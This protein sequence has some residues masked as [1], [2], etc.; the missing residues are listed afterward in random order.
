MMVRQPR[1]PAG[2]K[3]NREQVVAD[4][5][6]RAAEQVRAIVTGEDWA[7]W[8][9]VAA[10]FP[11]LG[12]TNVMLVAAQ[13]PAATFLA[14][15]EEWQD[16]GRQVRKGEP[17]IQLIAEPGPGLAVGG[18]SQRAYP[19]TRAS[20]EQVGRGP[21]LAY[22][23]DVSQTSGPPDPD[24]AAP[25]LADGG[26]ARP[27]LWDA[28]T[29]LARREGFAVERA[30]CVAGDSETR[31]GAHRIRISP[32]LHSPAAARAL[33][34]ELGHV[35]AHASPGNPPGAST[36]GCRGI[37]KVE[38]DSIACIVATRL[39]MDTSIYTWP[40]V[41]SWAGG[42]PRARPEETV[43]AAG[44][45]I[46]Q[47]AGLAA[48]HLDVALFGV[49]GRHAP[50]VRHRVLGF[51]GTPDERAVPARRPVTDS[52]PPVAVLSRMLVDAERFYRVHLGDKWVPGYLAARGLDPATV[53]QWRIGYAATGWTTL[54]SH[55]R[56]L[57][58]GD[59]AIE[60]AGLARRSSR[61][62]LIDYFRDRVMLAVR[63]ERGRIAGFIGRAHP[64]AGADVPKYLNS[65]ETAL[66]TK[67]D[68]LFGLHEARE[69]LAHGVTPVIVEGPF[70]AIAVSMAGAGRYVGLAPCGT[71]FTGR[72]AA[73]IDRVTDMERTGVVVALDGDR[74]G[75]DGIVKAYEILLAHTGKLSA[76]ILPSGQDPAGIL[77]TDGPTALCDALRHTE[78]LAQVV[79]DTYLDRWG[80]QLE[81]A[82][83]Q[84]A[85]MRS[86]ARLIAHTL[87]V[88]AADA[89]RRISG[90]REFAI[91][92]ADTDP[93]LD[94]GPA[95]DRSG[96]T[97][98]S[99]LPDCSS[100]RPDRMRL[101]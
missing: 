6:E 87:P 38:A 65:P 92:D 19:A 93:I 29:W 32:G 59:A 49:P 21:Q 80:R 12:F 9:R 67:G 84:L 48:A 8:L 71:A 24:L 85:A 20:R 64:G 7:A 4:L 53:Q 57:G 37:Q 22:V 34:H 28:L 44:E 46:T 70:D 97:S 76:A 51:A 1:E 18:R 3:R 36:A 95:N 39:G 74:A 75:R 56:R 26:G 100:S 23:W 91:L 31:W 2:S 101:L 66:Y 33:V 83:G 60:A 11:V 72:Q 94:P 40:Y 99:G 63:D 98:G 52:A 61:G 73:A 41:A 96:A 54:T 15:Y 27:G 25:P 35:L 68:L 86:A 78:S 88:G 81:H 17:G 79:I 82:E 47:A 45:R 5:R 43:R 55:L 77:Q 58:Y 90:G 16:K 42:D 89:M 30:D 13:Q 50:G 62:T 69:Q 14:T 10:R